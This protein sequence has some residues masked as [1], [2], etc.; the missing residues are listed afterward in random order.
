MKNLRRATI[1]LAKARPDL[2]PALLPLLTS[3]L[4]KMAA[5]KIP[6]GT[7]PSYNDN[8]MVVPA[9]WGTGGVV[10]L[11]MALR[12]LAPLYLRSD[13]NVA[14]V[15]DPRRVLSK[16][17]LDK[18]EIGLPNLIEENAHENYS[19]TLEY[20]DFDAN[21]PR[22]RDSVAELE[23]VKNIRVRIKEIVSPKSGLAGLRIVFG[24]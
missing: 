1:R 13:D 6:S 8:V 21:S 7:T 19:M 4:E 2:R 22:V 9:T 20:E 10:S 5:V 18:L 16:V 11:H 17:G 3:G 23:A 24:R 14:Y 15:V 12:A